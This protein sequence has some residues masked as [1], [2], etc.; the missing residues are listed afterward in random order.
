MPHTKSAEK[1]NRQTEKRNLRNRLVKKNLKSSLRDA[2]DAIKAGDAGKT[3]AAINAANKRLDKAAAHKN[4]H[5]NKANRLKSR[6][7]KRLNKAKAAT[8]AK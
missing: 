4:I 3:T 7:A 5:K 8:A 1:R 2:Q 6:L